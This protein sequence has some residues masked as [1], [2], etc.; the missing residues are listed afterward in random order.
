MEQG[1]ASG[2][3]TVREAAESLGLFSDNVLRAELARREHARRPRK[4]PAF[5]CENCGAVGYFHGYFS[6][7]RYQIQHDQFRKAHQDCLAIYG[8]GCI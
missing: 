5:T 2:K 4:H 8:G 6:A 7:W 1:G 3:V